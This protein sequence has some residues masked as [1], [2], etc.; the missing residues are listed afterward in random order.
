MISRRGLL[1]LVVVAPFAKG[2]AAMQPPQLTFTQKLVR[3]AK[4][5]IRR[6]QYPMPKMPGR[7]D[8]KAVLRKNSL[9]T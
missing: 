2:I 7:K 4:Q 1:Q 5:V 3:L 6:Q 9:W 8:L